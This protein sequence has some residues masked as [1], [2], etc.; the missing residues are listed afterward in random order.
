MSNATSTTI[1]KELPVQLDDAYRDELKGRAV[2]HALAFA[3][4]E[5]KRAD[6][7]KLAKA[8]REKLDGIAKILRDG[9]ERKPVLCDE[10][11]DFQRNEVRLVRR[12]TGDVAE[13]RAMTT[14]ERQEQMFEEPGAGK[15]RKLRDVSAVPAPVEDPTPDPH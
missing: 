5:A 1:T 13:T 12:D 3:D 8:E 4:L 15:K 9:V 11:S 2:V 7:A 14:A 6:L 10:V